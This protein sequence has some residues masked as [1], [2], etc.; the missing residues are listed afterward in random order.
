M[1]M[2]S[3]LIIYTPTPRDNGNEQDRHDRPRVFGDAHFLE[4]LNHVSRHQAD[5]DRLQKSGLHL[6]RKIAAKK[7][8]K[9]ARLACDGVGIVSPRTGNI[10]ISEADPMSRISFSRGACEKSGPPPVMGAKA[11][12]AAM[13]IPPQAMNGIAYETPVNRC[14]RSFWRDSSIEVRAAQ[15]CAV[16][17]ALFM[18]CCDRERYHKATIGVTPFE[19]PLPIEGLSYN[20]RQQVGIHLSYSTQEH[21]VPGVSSQ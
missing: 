3:T 16:A 17:K 18:G 6:P 13:R 14:S 1:R 20:P 9:Q 8:G 10:N 19:K 12:A 21:A 7:A 5:Q 2:P 4:C 11:I 15:K